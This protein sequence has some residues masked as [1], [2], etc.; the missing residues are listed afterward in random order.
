MKI[1]N[2]N[3]HGVEPKPGKKR[4]LKSTEKHAQK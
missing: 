1:K 2:E 4:K 3:N